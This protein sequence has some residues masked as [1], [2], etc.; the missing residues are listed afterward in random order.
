MPH[1]PTSPSPTEESFRDFVSRY[2][3]EDMADFEHSMRAWS[4]GSNYVNLSDE[5]YQKLR[6][7]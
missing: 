6:S 2:N 4:L 1:I 5:Q 3:L 7:R